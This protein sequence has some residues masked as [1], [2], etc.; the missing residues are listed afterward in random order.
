MLIRTWVF[1]DFFRIG[2]RQLVAG[3]RFGVY[4]LN[5]QLNWQLESESATGAKIGYVRV[6]GRLGLDRVGLG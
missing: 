2:N 6:G 4:F 3:C 5:R 1:K